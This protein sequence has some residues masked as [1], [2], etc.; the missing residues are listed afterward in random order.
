MTTTRAALISTTL[1]ACVVQAGEV[2]GSVGAPT[3]PA[4]TT[5]SEAADALVAKADAAARAGQTA[6]AWELYSQAWPLD[7][8]SA[9]PARGIC[10]LALALG[11]QKKAGEACQRALTLGWGAEDMRNRVASWVTGPS[12]PV[13]GDVVSASFMADGAVR[14][15]ARE[16]WGYLAW[17]DIALRLRDRDLLD[18]SLANLRRVA[19]EHEQTK[20]LIAR[21]EAGAS[22]WIRMGRWAGTLALLA[23]A[24]HALARRIRSSRRGRR[25]NVLALVSAALLVVSAA[26]DARADEGPPPRPVVDDAHPEASFQAVEKQGNPLAVGDLLMELADR[27]DKATKRG[28]HAAAARYWTAVTKAVPDRTYGWARLCE[29]LDAPGQ[30]EQALA[31]CRNALTRQGTTTVGDYTHFVRLL[32]AKNAPL[33]TSERK[34]VGVAIAQLAAEPKAAIDTERLR[35]DLAAHEHDIAGLESC[36]AKLV[37]AAPE[38]LRTI[39]SEWAL[40]VA[41]GDRAAAERFVDRIRATGRN[42]KTVD[43]MEDAMRGLPG[44][45]PTRI[46]RAIRWGV[47][48]ALLFL[49]SFFLYVGTGWAR[50]AWR[51]RQLGGPG[52]KRHVASV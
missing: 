21:A 22:I 39:S 43:A 52:G 16:P 2:G 35:C 47:S 9:A 50:S 45:R 23:T 12:L 37:A 13:M 46:A 15:A 11:Q 4:A 1:L 44:G 31:A 33:T 19:P 26:R 41:K 40:S 49:V 10:R 6:K 32:L 34:Q 38:D 7:P 18:A 48:G 51:R 30:R 14:V 24:V 27:G 5:S 8:A 29:A 3:R 25:R 28:D 17:G 20:F 42:G 36:S